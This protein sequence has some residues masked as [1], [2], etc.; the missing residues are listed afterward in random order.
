MAAEADNEYLMI[1]STAMR[2]HQH[3]AG[4]AGGHGDFRECHELLG[5]LVREGKIAGLRIDHIDCLRQPEDYLQRVQTLDR[6]SASKPLYVLI[7]KILAPGEVVGDRWATHGTTGYDFIFQLANVLVNTCADARLNEIYQSFTGENKPY[8]EIVYEK[9]KLIITELFV[10][11]ESN[12]G[13]ELVEI[14]SVDRDWRDLT[15]HELTIVVSEFMANMPVYRTYRRRQHPVSQADRRVI[16]EMCA[17]ALLAIL[18]LI[19]SPLNLSA[20]C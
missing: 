17:R 8:P 19:R 12:L 18:A 1:D 16:E 9:K 14:L 10:N 5:R 7:E 20:T 13:S 2:V 3:G 4:P 15:R 6:P 11:A